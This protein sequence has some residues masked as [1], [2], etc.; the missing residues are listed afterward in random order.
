MPAWFHQHKPQT[1]ALLPPEMAHIEAMLGLGG[2]AL[3]DAAEFTIAKN[4]LR[5]I[6][7]PLRISVAVFRKIRTNWMRLRYRLRVRTSFNA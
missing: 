6:M 1:M 4:A 7:R 2:Q 3:F 5:R